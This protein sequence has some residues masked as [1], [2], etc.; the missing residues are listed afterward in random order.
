MA[1]LDQIIGR[2]PQLYR[3]GAMVRGVLGAPAVQV[4]VVDQV[5]R[6]IQRAHW[7]ETTLNLEEAARIAGVLD[8]APEAWQTL[9][10]YRG[11]VN[12]LRDARLREGSVTPRA[13]QVFVAEYVRA[14]AAATGERVV[15]EPDVLDDPD[16]WATVPSPFA[17]ALV[18]NP[19]RR[20]F[21]TPSGAQLEPLAQFTVQQR[22]IDPALPSLLFIGTP[23]AGESGLVLVN[24]TTGHALSYAGVVAPGQRLWLTPES[25]GTMRARLEDDDT[26]HLLRS[27]EGVTPG[28]PWTPADEVTPPRAM[29]LLPGTNQLW[30]LPLARYDLRGLDRATLAMPDLSLMEGRWDNTAFDA[31]VFFQEPGVL[32]R[33]GWREAVPASFEIQLPSQ[34]VPGGPDGLDGTLT[35][36]AQLN[37]A[38]DGAVNNLRA[39]GVASR[40]VLRPFI[41]AQGQRD[42]LAMVLPKMVAERGSVGADRLLDAGGVFEV[43]RYDD[44]TYR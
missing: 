20:V 9:G 12:A 3:D 31:S 40:V 24:V 37:D 17:P 15:P 19:K 43:T 5:M 2:L 13:L 32:L 35:A 4:E 16:E 30:F 36:R 26:T 27:I 44:S 22:G 10:T 21:F 38:L 7:F 28:Q 6:E 1:H 8:I 41:E 42:R 33:M 29:T 18:E 23:V 25:G 11:W 14:F 34:L 39:A